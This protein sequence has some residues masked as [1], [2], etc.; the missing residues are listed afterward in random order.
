MYKTTEFVECLEINVYI[1]IYILILVYIKAANLTKCTMSVGVGDYE[2]KHIF[3]ELQ[4][5]LFECTVIPLIK[6]TLF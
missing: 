4:I 1:Y 2:I 6:E 3:F 5:S